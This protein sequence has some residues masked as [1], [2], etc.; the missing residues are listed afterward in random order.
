MPTRM[1]QRSLRTATSIT[2]ARVALAVL[3]IASSAAGCAWRTAAAEHYFG[4]LLI[5]FSPPEGDAP[6]VKQVL[7]LGLMGEGGH[8]WGFS[9]GVV[10]RIAVWP[11]YG[12][13]SKPEASHRPPWSMLL[14]GR[15]APASRRWHFS[16]FYA[17]VGSSEPPVLVTRRLWGAQVVAGPEATAASLGIVSVTR[18]DVPDDAVSLVHYDARAPLAARFRVWRAGSNQEL[19]PLHLIEEATR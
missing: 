6:A 11:A 15:V 2:I 3:L 8:Q 10:E 17:R 9:V 16:P 13:G 4:P 7:G 1:K 14:A 12:P 19:P 5:R 18:V